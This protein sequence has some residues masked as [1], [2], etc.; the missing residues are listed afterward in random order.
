[1]WP[2]SSTGGTVPVRATV[3]LLSRQ[4]TEV[5]SPRRNTAGDSVG[6][7]AIEGNEVFLLVSRDQKLLWLLT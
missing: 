5:R 6:T 1:M 2:V 4:A 3:H 7:L